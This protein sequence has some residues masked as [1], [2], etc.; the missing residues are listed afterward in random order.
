[1]EAIT[2]IFTT[3]DQQEMKQ[4]FKEIIIEQFKND[5]ESNELFL[6]D[7]NEVSS[8]VDAAFIEAIEEIKAE[9]KKKLRKQMLGIVEN[10]D[11]EKL[12]LLKKEIK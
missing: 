3:E 6:F 7:P 2:K 5:I 10:N 11:I 12:L 4:S 9:F 8:M 1:M